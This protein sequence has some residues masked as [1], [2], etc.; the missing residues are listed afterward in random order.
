MRKFKSI[1]LVCSAVAILFTSCSKVTEVKQPQSSFQTS[2]IDFK[3]DATSVTLSQAR[4][5]AQ[6]FL[7]SKSPNST[8]TINNSET[9]VKA[10]KAYFH[11]INT[12]KGFVIV[13]SDSLYVPIIAFDTA[14]HFSFDDKF[15][16]AGL[17]LWMNKHAHQLDYVRNTISPYSDSIGKIDKKMWLMYGNIKN[18]N[19]TSIQNSTS[20]IL[21]SRNVAYSV[22]SQQPSNSLITTYNKYS[23][24]IPPFL[25]YVY[26]DQVDPYNQY[27]PNVPPG[28]N[29]PAQSNGKYLTGCVPTAMAQI[30]DYWQYPHNYDWTNMAPYINLTFLPGGAGPQEPLNYPALHP[31]RFSNIAFLMNSIAR[32]PVDPSRNQSQLAIYSTTGSG[33]SAFVTDIP[34]VFSEFGFSKPGIIGGYNSTG[35]SPIFSGPANNGYTNIMINEILNNRPCIV[36]GFTDETPILGGAWYSASGIGHAWVCDGLQQDYWQPVYTFTYYTQQSWGWLPNTTVTYGSYSLVSTY[37]HFN[38]GFGVANSDSGP[39]NNGYYDCSTN[40]TLAPDGNTY[41]YFQQV[42]YNIQP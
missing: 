41:K 22:S 30:M 24:K 35:S 13:S 8:I 25:N 18:K 5:L 2:T 11:I 28:D 19:I 33:T 12:N 42:V 16:N 23:S 6:D 26:W 36:G 15:M 39:N 29:G 9:V 27:Y 40:Y 17:S 7:Q 31:E 37:L 10:G 20:S 4:G 34:Y 3:N 1:I 38:W 14:N 32:S 21:N